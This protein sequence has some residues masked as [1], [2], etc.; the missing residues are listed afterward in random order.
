MRISIYLLGIIS[1]MLSLHQFSLS[2]SAKRWKKIPITQVNFPK[3]FMW[4]TAD[5]ALQTEGV[6]TSNNATIENSWTVWE[7]ELVMKEG[8]LQS[9]YPQQNRAGTACNRWHCY[10]QDM[11][12][13]ADLGMNA[14]R[15]SIEWSKIEPQKGVF[16]PIAMQH[17]I[18]Y[19]KSMLKN[20]L[21]PIPTLF[22]HAWPLWFEYKEDPTRGFAFEDSKNIQDFVDFAVY[23]FKSFQKAGLS[24]Y[25]KIWL[26]FNEPVGYAM[27]GYLHKQLP[28]GKK[29]ELVLC[30]KVVKNMLDAHIAVFDA[31]K[32]IDPTLKISFAHIMNPIEPYHKWN[33]LDAVPASIFDFLLND[34]A[35]LY[36]KTGTFYW[37]TSLDIKKI[38]SCICSLTIYTQEFNPRA[39]NKLD[40]IGVNYYTHTL[41]KMFKESARPHE[42]LADGYETKKIKAIYPEGFYKSL[43]KASMLKIPILIT[44]NGFAAKTD[45]LREEYLQKHLYILSKAINDGMD[46]RGYLFWTLT[47]CF[48]W[49]SY[50][51]HGI[52]HVDFTTQKRTLKKGASYLI[53]VIKNHSNGPAIQILA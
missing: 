33:P 24:E 26:T 25:I 13:A 41:L 22:H 48:G 5:S 53:D 11:K 12:R 19:V 52:Y 3:N 43:K 44:E 38:I 27:A 16:D 30:G 21:Q 10:D 36:F 6:V 50:S 14:H 20:G 28:P 15:F 23:V 29:L 51:N 39:L 31:L 40:F 18:E 1:L 7:K 32:K 9:R 17:Y 49:G 42:K 47:D 45:A 8:K 4:G 37:I 46:I 35:L 2:I 34:V